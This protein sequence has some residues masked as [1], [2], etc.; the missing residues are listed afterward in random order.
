[1]WIE[2]NYEPLFIAPDYFVMGWL[3]RNTSQGAN[4][5]IQYTFNVLLESCNSCGDQDNWFQSENKLKIKNSH[6]KIFYLRWLLWPQP[7]VLWLLTVWKWPVCSCPCCWPQSWP[8]SFWS[9]GLVQRLPFCLCLPAAYLNCY[10]PRLFEEISTLTSLSSTKNEVQSPAQK[11]IS[12]KLYWVHL[13]YWQNV[14]NYRTH[15]QNKKKC[16][17]R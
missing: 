1:M 11:R 5:T 12:L 4:S 17:F 6:C 3:D 8:S 14:R 16:K 13:P 15:F 2:S 9:L 10:Q 7:L